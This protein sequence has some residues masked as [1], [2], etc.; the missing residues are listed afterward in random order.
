MTSGARGGA[1]L[2]LASL[3]TRPVDAVYS[4]C[5]PQLDF[6]SGVPPRYFFVSGRAN[7]LNPDGVEC[8]YLSED[9]RVAD[10]EYARAWEVV[11]ESLQPKLTFHV[12]A[13][14]A[15][16][17]DLGT[18]RVLAKLGLGKS[19]LFRPWR[20]AKRQTR[21]QALGAA[22][23]DQTRIT[24]VRYPSFAARALV[25]PGWNLVVYIAALNAPDKLEV[26]GKPGVL[27]EVLP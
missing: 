16:V 24:A 3:P 15:N 7:R 10:A 12:R 27:L 13:C 5:V 18:P 4:R 11:E 8:L 1:P 23:A 17:L 22:I 25:P 26:L 6:S 14:I 2:P 19:D 21:L 9:D 20:L